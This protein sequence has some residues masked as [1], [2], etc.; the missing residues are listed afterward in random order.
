M[1]IQPK[2]IEQLIDR[3]NRGVATAAEEHRLEQCI[4]AGLVELEQ[5][6]ELETLGRHLEAMQY[7]PSAQS[8]RANFQ[9]LLDREKLKIKR[10]PR[11]LLRKFF[12]QQWT[13][14]PAL[15]FAIIA[16]VLISGLSFGYLLR[17]AQ[18]AGQQEYIA[19]M[20]EELQSVKEMMMLTLL[21]KESTNDRLK[22][23]KISE[24]LPD[25][26]EQV[27]QA[28]LKTLNSD[29]NVSVRLAALDA[30]RPYTDDPQVR[31]GLIRSIQQQHSPLVQVAL[32]E[33]MVALQEK[34][35][36]E[37]FEELLKSDQTPPEVKK[38][39]RSNIEILL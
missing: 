16:I 22:A 12:A 29:K 19:Q 15:Q 2:E 14:T 18:S 1:N 26:S 37:Q 20:A 7:A 28:L 25:A 6:Q 36:V 10:S 5:L 4:E 13:L 31:E 24:D 3:F 8:L 21:E 35:S 39:I 23:V 38:Q 27:T 34:R 9:H 32:A 33:L 30:L 11:N 17:P